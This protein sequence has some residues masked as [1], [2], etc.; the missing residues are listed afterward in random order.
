MTVDEERV[1]HVDCVGGHSG[2]LV[3]RTLWVSE[4]SLYSR[5]SLILSQCRD[6]RMVVI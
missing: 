1:L 6:L 2:W 3:L 4:R 5:H